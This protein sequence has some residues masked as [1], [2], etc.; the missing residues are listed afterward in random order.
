MFRGDTGMG[1]AEW[2]EEV[3]ASMRARR[4]API[5]QAFFIYDHLEGPAKEE[6]GLYPK[7]D[8]EDP[9]KVIAI[10]Q[11]EYGCQRSYVALQ[12]DFFSRR[13]YTESVRSSFRKGFRKYSTKFSQYFPQL[14]RTKR[15]TGLYYRFQ[16]I[17]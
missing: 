11:E 2:V 1:I 9:E 8:R 5:D 17:Y 3:R 6:I 14:Y 13:N 4:L 12:K 15:V 10:L 16:N 7:S